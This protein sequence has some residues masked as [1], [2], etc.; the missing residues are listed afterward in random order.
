MDDVW[1]RS[2]PQYHSCSSRF[3][4]IFD[5]LESEGC[6]R[7]ALS[8]HPSGTQDESTWCFRKLLVP[9]QLSLAS[10][11]EQA[12]HAHWPAEGHGISQVEVGPDSLLRHFEIKR[13]LLQIKI[14]AAFVTWTFIPQHCGTIFE[15]LYIS[16]FPLVFFDVLRVDISS[17][18]WLC[19]L[20]TPT[21]YAC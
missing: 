14:S 16:K 20:F 18:S 13:T 15:H 4:E 10:A 19:N 11:T 17:F 9:C 21:S 8:E 12:L 5:F 1:K 3:D 6:E 2:I 7:Q